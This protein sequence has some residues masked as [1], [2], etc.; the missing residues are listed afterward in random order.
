V[1][2]D[3]GRLDRYVSVQA[4]ITRTK[5]EALEFNA[6]MEAI[7]RANAVA[8]WTPDGH[9][10]LTN[11]LMRTMLRTDRSQEQV[12]PLSIVL[13]AGEQESLRHSQFLTKEVMVEC[14]GEPVWLSAS[15]QSI[16]DFRGTIVRFV[17]YASDISARRRAISETNDLME[18]FLGRINAIATEITGIAGQTN[19]LSLNATIEPH[20][21]A[22]PARDLP[23]S[24]TRSAP[25][26]GAP[27][28]PPRRSPSW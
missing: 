24:P 1:F 19:L 27:G 8:E 5:T 13:S 25:L 22:R 7:R 9:L 15:F 4:N 14:G 11:D 28:P 6:R 10:V 17:M 26:P 18:K 21:P 23:S 2:D 16:T 12:L 3:S 20:G